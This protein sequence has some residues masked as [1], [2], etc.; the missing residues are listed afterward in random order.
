MTFL[1][2]DPARLAEADFSPPYM[3]TEYTYLV[4]AG[5]T[6]RLVADVDQPGVRIA[7]PRG[8]GSETQVSFG[9]QTEVAPDHLITLSA[10][11]SGGRDETPASQCC[12]MQPRAIGFRR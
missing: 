1:V 3:Q 10:R 7:V 11:A 4:L 12:R 6:K 9:P 5:S 2:A 8:D